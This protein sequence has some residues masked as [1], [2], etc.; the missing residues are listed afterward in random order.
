MG[1]LQLR[2]R[3]LGGGPELPFTRNFGNSGGKQK[4]NLAR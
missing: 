3:D 4:G 2:K 1:S